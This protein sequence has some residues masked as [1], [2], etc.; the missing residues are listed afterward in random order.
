MA[1]KEVLLVTFPVD[2]GNRTLESNLQSIFREDMD[3]YRFAEQHALRIDSKKIT[4]IESVKYRVISMLALRKIVR[5]YTKAKKQILFNGLSPAVFSFGIWNP[6]N[7][8]IVFDWTRTLY[9][10][11]LN[12]PYKK[13]LIFKLHK[14]VLN[15]CPKF[16][17]WT[18]SIIENLVNVYGVDQN[19]LHKVPTPF[20][21]DKLSIQPRKTPAIPRVLFIGGDLV[22]KGGDLLIKDWAAKIGDKC[23][24]TMMTNDP[25]AKIDG[26]KYLPGVKYGSEIH[27]RTFE[28]ND[29]LILPTRI[30]AYPQVI[31]EAA[32]AGLAVI[33]TKFALG[34]REVVDENESGYIAD[35]PE[36]C[37]DLLNKLCETPSLIDAFK[38]NGYDLMQRKFSQKTI[39]QKYLDVLKIPID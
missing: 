39:R 36:Q 23:T 9:P 18:D 27:K 13:D 4:F 24:L 5:K 1:L 17:C 16:L 3:F 29:I 20:M 22:R 2:L 10:T 37:L 21:I 15:K 14:I 26:V 19:I 28:E 35:T 25:T 30:D 8:S 12:Q 11:I 32:S 31:G 7:T 38:S 33:T 6:K 34:A